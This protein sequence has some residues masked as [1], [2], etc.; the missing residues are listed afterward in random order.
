MYFTN[1]L[2]KL[3]LIQGQQAPVW[4]Q[5]LARHKFGQKTRLSKRRAHPIYCKIEHTSTKTLWRCISWTG[6]YGM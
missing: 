4:R 5:P 2:D 1:N 6:P 3:F